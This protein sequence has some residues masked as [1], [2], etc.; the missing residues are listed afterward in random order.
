MIMFRLVELRFF[1]PMRIDSVSEKGEKENSEKTLIHYERE[2]A[3]WQ[4]TEEK[5]AK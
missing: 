1:S 3:C 2:S 5:Y 4:R